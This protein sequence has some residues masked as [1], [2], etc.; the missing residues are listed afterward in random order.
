MFIFAV[1][2]C[3]ST[4]SS[5]AVGTSAGFLDVRK[6]QHIEGVIAEGSRDVLKLLH[7]LDQIPTQRA[8]QSYFPN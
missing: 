2:G 5:R 1:F 6:A 7:F 4:E 3:V 8:V